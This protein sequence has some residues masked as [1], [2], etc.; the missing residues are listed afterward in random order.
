MWTVAGSGD[1][2]NV[3]AQWLARL[4]LREANRRIWPAGIL[5]REL[6]TWSLNKGSSRLASAV[7]SSFEEG[8]ALVSQ[9]YRRQC[10]LVRFLLL[11]LLHHRRLRPSLHAGDAVLGWSAGNMAVTFGRPNLT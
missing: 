4:R 7:E 11:L 10:H 1:S 6:E 9:S 8:A 3:V 5:P 2:L